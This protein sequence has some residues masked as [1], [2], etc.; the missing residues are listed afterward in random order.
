MCPSR[1]AEP[2]L[3]CITSPSKTTIIYSICFCSSFFFRPQQ[4]R[5]E[6]CN[7]NLNDL[8]TIERRKIIVLPRNQVEQTPK[9]HF[10]EIRW[11]GQRIWNCFW[12]WTKIFVDKWWC[13]II[14]RFDH[15]FFCLNRAISNCHEKWY[16][17]VKA[18]KLWHLL[19]FFCLFKIYVYA[20]KEPFKVLYSLYVSEMYGYIYANIYTY[21]H[22]GDVSLLL[23]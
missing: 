4:K 12:D 3:D 10:S 7:D 15:I 17:F 8:N 19:C 11:V 21:S 6:Q 1:A 22:L 9:K 14:I 18:L 23:W 2:T 5:F 16:E 13:A 20:R